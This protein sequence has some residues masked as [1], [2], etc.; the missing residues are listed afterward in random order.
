MRCVITR[1]LPLP[2]PATIRRG[3]PTSGGFALPGVQSFEDIGRHRHQDHTTAGRPNG[4]NF[5]F[6]GCGRLRIRRRQPHPRAQP[7]SPEQVTNGT[8]R[9]SPSVKAQPRP[10]T[11][12]RTYVY[13]SHNIR[14]LT[15][16]G[17][18]KQKL[19]ITVDAELIPIAKRYARS[20][21]VSL[22]SLVEQSLREA[23]GS[24]TCP[25]PHDGGASSGGGARRPPLRCTG[26]EVPTMMLLD[27]D[28]LIESPM[29]D[30]PT[31]VRLLSS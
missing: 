29:T 22:S 15:T 16:G 19:T 11:A 23:A 14:I 28:V 26:Q 7:P 5:R 21:G 18:M 25:S 24:Q 27:T 12:A 13:L 30:A 4:R 6:R 31:R 3:P 8:L 2:G 17:D 9:R 1:V 10:C 20:R